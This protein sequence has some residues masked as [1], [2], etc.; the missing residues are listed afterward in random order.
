MSTRRLAATLVAV[1]LGVAVAH[2]EAGLRSFDRACL[3]EIN[4]VLTDQ[5]ATLLFTTERSARANLAREVDFVERVYFVG[6]VM[7]DSLTCVCRGGSWRDA[8]AAA[9]RQDWPRRTWLRPAYH[10]PA[11]ERR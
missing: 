2:V 6:N 9:G 8:F 11:I 4:R 5:I 10:A 1:K 7:I 3:A